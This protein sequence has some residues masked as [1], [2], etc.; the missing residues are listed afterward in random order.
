MDSCYQDFRS[1]PEIDAQYDTSLSVP[2]EAAELQRYVDRAAQAR[3]SLRCHLDV[4]YG[5]S[6]AETLDIFPAD[7]PGAPVFVFIH[8]G[9][10]RSSS[11]KD[12]SGVALGL[13]PLGITTVVIDYAL[14]PAV[15]LDE[16]TRQARAALAWVVRHIGEYGGDAARV[17]VGGHSAGAHLAAMC[18]LSH[19][20][21]IAAG[22]PAPLAA[23][24]LVS[25]L[26][27]LEPLRRS[28]LQPVLRLDDG[29]VAR[30]SP[31]SAEVPRC[32]TPLWITWGGDE[33]A[34]F[35]RQSAA[36]HAAW[37]AAGNPSR[38]SALPGTHHFSA[39]HGFEEPGSELCQWLADR[40]GPG[41]HRAISGDRS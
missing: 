39:I 31:A 12:F 17:A 13:Q 7:E 36:F 33:T 8:G 21:G 24:L 22:A 9:Y 29:I 28:Y 11:S 34:E 4:P 35:A 2:H 40:L 14:C 41:S 16:I 30:N 15:T 32:T 10:W 37:Q 1:Q 26:Y 25:G 3:A 19:A 5:P 20:G 6:A 18:L 38:L 23:G 27:E